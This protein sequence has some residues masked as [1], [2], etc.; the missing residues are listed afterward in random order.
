[1]INLLPNKV[2]AVTVSDTNYITDNVYKVSSDQS[3]L[4]VSGATLA[5]DTLTYTAHGYVTG[6]IIKFPTVG[7]VTGITT[8]LSYFVIRVD[9]NTIKVATSFANAAAG[10]S[11][12]LG[13]ATTTLPTMVR[14]DEYVNVRVEGTL[15]VGVSGDIT[16]LLQGAQD[17]NSTTVGSNVAQLFKNVPV[18]PFPYVVKKVF[19]TGTTAT[20]ILCAY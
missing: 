12:D 11:I 5:S 4:T 3:V 14:T 16:C 8:L 7:T 13:G 2:V 19:S 1:M 17:T 9:A 15:F 6:D 10:T 18:G 20:N